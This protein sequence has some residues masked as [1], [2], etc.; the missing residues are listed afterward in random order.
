MPGSSASAPPPTAIRRGVVMTGTIEGLP[1]PGLRMT[2]RKTPP[3]VSLASSS[4]QPV[5][6]QKCSK[7]LVA[8]GSV[9][10]TSSTAPGASGF[11]ARRAF[12]T[13]NG[14]KSP[15]ASSVASTVMLPAWVIVAPRQNQLCEDANKPT[16]LSATAA[17]HFRGAR[18]AEQPF[19]SGTAPPK[20]LVVVQVPPISLRGLS[21][22]HLAELG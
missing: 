3:G 9:A 13:G 18:T 6:A 4:S 11:S 20:P 16:G 2:K 5:V 17:S 1:H 22:P 21:H 14:H 7:S 19:P 15:V 12:N 10:S 8:P